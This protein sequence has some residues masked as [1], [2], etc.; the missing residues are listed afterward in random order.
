MA[1]A[2]KSKARTPTEQRLLDASTELRMLVGCVIEALEFYGSDDGHNEIVLAGIVARS[3]AIEDKFEDVLFDRV[4][5]E[6]H[7]LEKLTRT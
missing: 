3:R 4:G 7:R 6:R 2:M 5:R 1:A